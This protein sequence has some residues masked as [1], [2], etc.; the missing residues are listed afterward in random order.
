M[1]RGVAKKELAMGRRVL[2][3]REPLQ[4]SSCFSESGRNME[5]EGA[6]LE[7][8]KEPDSRCLNFSI[9]DPMAIC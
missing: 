6:L 9:E 4:R 7:R 1:S 2:D 8:S 3:R 5:K